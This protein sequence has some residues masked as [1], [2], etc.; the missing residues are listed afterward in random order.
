MTPSEPTAASDEDAARDPE[1]IR[2]GIAETREELGDT[3]EALA[4]KANVKAQAKAKVQA[5]KE[6]AREKLAGAGEATPSSLGAGGQQAAATVRENPI[7]SAAVGALVAGLVV[8]WMFG[9]R[10]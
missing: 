8:G 5:A 3:V 4:A 6:T 2:A 7:P 10:G 1:Q 9:R